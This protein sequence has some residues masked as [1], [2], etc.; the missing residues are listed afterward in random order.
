[1]TGGDDLALRYVGLAVELFRATDPRYA[2]DARNAFESYLRP[3]FVAG[4]P[5]TELELDL[6][7]VDSHRATPE[8][9]RQHPAESWDT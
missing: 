7:A 1:V 2:D 8:D 3:L 6:L 9:L 5:D 4:R